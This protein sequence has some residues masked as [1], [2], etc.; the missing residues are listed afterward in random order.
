MLC[1]ISLPTNRGRGK[2]LISTKRFVKETNMLLKTAKQ[3]VAIEAQAI[4][5]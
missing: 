5:V 3:V 2:E 4:K 1:K